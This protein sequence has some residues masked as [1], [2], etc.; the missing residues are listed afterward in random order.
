MILI[1]CVCILYS[2]SLWLVRY[3]DNNI[4]SVWEKKFCSKVFELKGAQASSLMCHAINMVT[5]NYIYVAGRDGGVGR[6]EGEKKIFH[7][8][9]SL[10][11]IG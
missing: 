7:A 4:R 2:V 6:R 1:V 5:I 11:T 3:S 10:P 9:S 8:N